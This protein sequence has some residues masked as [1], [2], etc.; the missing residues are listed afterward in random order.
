MHVMDP[1]QKRQV[2]NFG[3]STTYGTRR[4]LK[5]FIAEYTQL[6][7]RVTKYS[8]VAALV[9]KWSTIADN[10]GSISSL[11]ISIFTDNFR[12]KIS[13]ISIFYGIAVWATHT[14]RSW[15]VPNVFAFNRQ[16]RISHLLSWVMTSWHIPL[17]CHYRVIR[18]PGTRPGSLLGTRRV[19][20]K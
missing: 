19:V 5:Y 2:Q 18:Y 13:A 6:S 8:T 9:N 20:S 10:T 3:H 1:I 4:V 14:S 17:D 16:L 11:P 15:K 12:S 7:T